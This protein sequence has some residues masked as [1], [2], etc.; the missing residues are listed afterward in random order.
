MLAHRGQ[1]V[2]PVL[3]LDPRI[4]TGNHALLDPGKGV[5]PE[6]A[7]GMTSDVRA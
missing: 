3:G 4:S 7:P 1:F 5:D 6:P 2:M